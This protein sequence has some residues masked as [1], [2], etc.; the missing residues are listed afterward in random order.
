MKANNKFNG[1]MTALLIIVIFI[2]LSPGCSSSKLNKNLEIYQN[3]RDDFELIIEIV[4]EYPEFFIT[5][6][7]VEIDQSDY[8]YNGISTEKY[9]PKVGANIAYDENRFKEYVDKIKPFFD[10]YELMVIYNNTPGVIDISKDG[11]FFGSYGWIYMINGDIPDEESLYIT[12]I[13]KIN[14]NWY[15]TKQV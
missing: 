2:L 4:K 3:N 7:D 11:S 8:Y 15:V 10:K 12:E 9:N 1:Y 6:D 13:I 14:E 5:R